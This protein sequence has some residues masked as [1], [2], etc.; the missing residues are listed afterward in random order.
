MTVTMAVSAR[1]IGSA[2]A[3]MRPGTL[4]LAVSGLLVAGCGQ[5]PIFESVATSSTGK[6]AATSLSIP[7]PP[8]TSGAAS[9]D[10]LIAVLGVKIN[11]ATVGPS[12]WTALPGMAGFN[13]TVCASDDEG[14]ACQ[15]AVFY[16]IA[17]GS[18]TTAHFSWVTLYQAAGAVLRYSRFD[19]GSPFGAV[20]KQSGSS[21]AP[22]AP[23][24]TTVRSE[25]RVLRI[26]LS[27]ADNVRGS[28]TTVIL[29]SDPPTLR[30]NLVSFPPA[31][32]SLATGCGPPLSGCSYTNEAV[33]LAASDGRQATAGAP[34][35]A[36]WS[37]PG[38]D[39]WVGVTIEI[40]R[41]PGGGPVVQ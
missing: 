32:V 40:K 33:G 7:V 15:L 4:A 22:T 36:S 29:G 18:E 12:G 30:F 14:I 26:A 17:S 16:K 37:L 27:E 9:G 11:P 21:N 6:N 8:S 2:L 41:P 34:G 23:S 13:G 35:T 1:R 39:Q 24:V 19:T 3:R 31:S 38:T 28:L 20:G 25:S 5:E 10:L